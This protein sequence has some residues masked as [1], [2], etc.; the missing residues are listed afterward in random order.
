M[1]HGRFA[2]I[3]L[4]VHS[5]LR[6]SSCR[7]SMTRICRSRSRS[8]S[9]TLGKGNR[10]GMS[11]PSTDLGSAHRAQPLSQER[12]PDLARYTL[13]PLQRGVE[14]EPFRGCYGGLGEGSRPSILVRAPVA[15]PPSPASLRKMQEEY[16]L[17]SELEPAYVVR[18][19]AFAQV[20]GRP[21]L[22]LEDPG[23]MPL[24]LLLDGAMEM[25]S[26]LPLAISAA[27]A[28]G[29]VHSRGLV[30]KDIKPANILVNTACDRA[31]LMG[32]GV[33]SRLPSGNRSSLPSSQPG[34][35]PTWPPSRPGA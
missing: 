31:W 15:D 20:H 12:V 7:P 18:S 34:P 35:W 14:F 6:I 11:T 9:S 26:F 1:T 27:P 4:E 33:A 25:A 23:G 24:D 5:S 17:R 10:I 2:K 13:Q 30:H 16:A 22:V 29:H 21:V 32:L 3:L 19:L 28:L 8:K